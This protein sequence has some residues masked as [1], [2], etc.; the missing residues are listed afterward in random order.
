M[1]SLVGWGSIGNECYVECSGSLPHHVALLHRN[2]TGVAQHLK[3]TTYIW[4]AQKMKRLY[5]CQ[6][7]SGTVESILLVR[8]QTLS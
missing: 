7:T 5:T 6:A 4:E 8:F 1:S 3:R 2:G